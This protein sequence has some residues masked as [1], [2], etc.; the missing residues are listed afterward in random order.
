VDEGDLV[1]D[2]AERSGDLGELPLWPNCLKFQGSEG[3]AVAVLEGST[4]SPGS[5]LHRA[6][7]SGLKSTC[8]RAKRRP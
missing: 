7:R 5:G 1:D 6:I 2:A 4:F 8:Q 3:I